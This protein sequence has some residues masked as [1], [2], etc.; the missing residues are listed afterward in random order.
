MPFFVLLVIILLFLIV[1]IKQVDQYETGLRFTFGKY[2]KMLKPGWR[3]VLPIF[4]GLIKVDMRVRA[5]DVPFQKAITKDNVSVSINAVIYY[6]VVA[7][8][9]SILEVENYQFA[10]SQ[11]AQTT[12]RNVAGEVD[13]D[14]L[15]SQREMVSEK[16]KTIVDKASDPWG[17]D[18]SS[19]ELKDIVLPEDMERTIAKQAEAE[20]EK[21]AVI[22]TARGELEASENMAAAAK[23]LHASPGALH[24]RTLQSLNDIS[25]DQSNTIVYTLPL[26][27][28]QSFTRQK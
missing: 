14:G 13:L 24:L 17:I 8:E 9:K 15:L 25:S 6:R 18:V 27:I 16:I 4:Q 19:V 10:I 12:M 21:R 7:S 1:T 23:V 2:S 26:E 28:L 20:R 11:L 22:I 5:V 3:I